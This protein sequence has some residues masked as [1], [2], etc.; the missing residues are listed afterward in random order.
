MHNNRTLGKMVAN[1][2]AISF[3]S[4]P[5]SWP[6][7]RLNR[8]C[9]NSSIFAQLKRIT[10]GQ[11][12]KRSQQHSFYYVTLAINRSPLRFRITANNLAKYRWS[13]AKESS[14]NLR[15]TRTCYF[16]NAFKTENQLTF[17]RGNQRTGWRIAEPSIVELSI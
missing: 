13:S 8:F 2:F 4:P 5:G 14:F 10:D 3:T 1:I 17:S 15:F 11:T 9:T 12:E 6:I 7:R 16:A